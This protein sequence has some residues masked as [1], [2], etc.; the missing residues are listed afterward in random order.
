MN[1]CDKIS[2]HSEKKTQNVNLCPSDKTQT[3]FQVQGHLSE[4]KMTVLA[5]Y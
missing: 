1:F 4:A 5:I 3:Y 2:Q